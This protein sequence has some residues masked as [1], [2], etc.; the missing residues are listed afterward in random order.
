M[1]NLLFD[2]RTA[3]PTKDAD[4]IENALAH[5]NALSKMIAND[6]MLLNGCKVTVMQ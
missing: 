6:P 2:A 5:A 1:K 3:G 4:F